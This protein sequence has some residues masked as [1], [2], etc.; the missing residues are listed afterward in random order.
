MRE[1][2]VREVGSECCDAAAL[3]GE[4]VHSVHGPSPLYDYAWPT[5]TVLNLSILAGLIHLNTAAVGSERRASL[6]ESDW[7]NL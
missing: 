2:D 6:G 3:G 7:R 5:H 4:V 1:S